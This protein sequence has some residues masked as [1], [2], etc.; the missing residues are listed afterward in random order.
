MLLFP[1]T[2]GLV[3]ATRPAPS[4]RGPS[5]QTRSRSRRHCPRSR[6]TCL[7]SSADAIYPL[8]RGRS[9][10]NSAPAS[11]TFFPRRKRKT[12]PALTASG[13][14]ISVAWR[15]TAPLTFSCSA[16]DRCCHYPGTPS[17]SSAPPWPS[18]PSSPCSCL[19]SRPC[20]LSP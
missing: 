20:G 19:S 12:V 18:H 5:T 2:G 8:F 15:Q 1:L 16:C 4:S 17:F 6:T 13:R 3:A 9:V 14:R 11:T 7:P 10:E